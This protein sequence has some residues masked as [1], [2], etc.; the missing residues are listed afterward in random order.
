M[1]ADGL[2]HRLGQHAAQERQGHVLVQVVVARCTGLVFGRGGGQQV[3]QVVQQGRDD[4][5]GGLTGFLGQVGALQ[6]M[7]ELAHGLAAVLLLAALGEQ[8]GDVVLG[9]CHGEK[10]QIMVLRMRADTT[11][12]RL[13]VTTMMSITAQV[14]AYW[15]PRMISHSTTPMPPAPTMPTTEAERT[16]ASKR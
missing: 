5:G 8:Q 12:I 15:K 16:L 2:Q 9:Q 7:V 3:A 14:S 13:T 6:R 10:P 4:G 1:H 11:S